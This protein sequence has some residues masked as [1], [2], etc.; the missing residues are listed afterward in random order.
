MMP[1]AMVMVRVGHEDG[2]SSQV[3]MQISLPT[4]S[5]HCNERCVHG[6]TDGSDGGEEVGR[7]RTG[8]P[9]TGTSVQRLWHK[10]SV[11]QSESR[12]SA[13]PAFVWQA[14]HL[15]DWQMESLS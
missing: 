2:V 3:M 4:R 6:L 10:E 8:G 7:R 9:G 15:C 11:S 12:M 13:E 5:P 14:E 1:V